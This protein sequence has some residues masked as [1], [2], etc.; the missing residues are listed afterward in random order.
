MATPQPARIVRYLPPVGSGCTVSEP[1]H[2]PSLRMLPL[3]DTVMELM[4]ALRRDLLVPHAFQLY[5]KVPI[6]SQ[7]PASPPPPGAPQHLWVLADPRDSLPPLP[8][9]D[10]RVVAP[11]PP[12]PPPPPPQP[13]SPS[14]SRIIQGPWGP[15]WV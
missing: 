11:I 2:W 5:V 3:G 14:V 8:M 7:F 9:L 4:E 15:V 6:A 13:P 10:V 1:E 12:P